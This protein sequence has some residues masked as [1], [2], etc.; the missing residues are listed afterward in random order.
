MFIVRHYDMGDGLAYNV[1]K[2]ILQDQKGF[3]W[4]ATWNGIDRFDG[5][6][7]RNFKSYPDDK[8][9]LNNNRIEGL[10][11]NSEGNL[12][13]RTYDRQLFLFNRETET[14]E[15]P[16]TEKHQPLIRDMKSLDN[17]I[18][19]IITES[20]DLYRIDD[21]QYRQPDGIRFFGRANNPNLGNTIYEIFLDGDGDEWILSDRG[22]I[23]E[24]RKKVNSNIPFRY[25]TEAGGIVYLASQNGYLATYNENG[26]LTPFNLPFKFDRI[27]RLKKLNEEQIAII[28]P[29]II[30]IYHT[31]DKTTQHFSPPEGQQF[32]SSESLFLDGKGVIW[33]FASGRNMICYNTAN[34]ER[35]VLDYP[36]LSDFQLTGGNTP[37]I[38]EDEHGEIWIFFRE[39]ILCTYNADRRQLEIARY[40][41]SEGNLR[42][43]TAQLR[44]FL[45]DTHHNLWICTRDGVDHLSFYKKTYDLIGNS[46]DEEVRGIFQ[47][48]YNRLW[49]GVKNG[50]I[51]LYDREYNHIGNL[52]G[53]GRIVQDN[54]AVFGATVYCF[55]RDDEGN[56]WI[57][58][59]DRGLF[60]LQPQN[61]REYRVTQYQPT[62]DP[63]SIS[64]LSVYSILQDSQKRMWIG[65]WGGGINLV[66]KDSVGNLQFIH[67]GNR[68]KNYPVEQ[69]G[70]V[71]YVYQSKNG[72]LMLGTTTGLITFSSRFDSPEEITFFYNFCTADRSDCLSNGNILYIF[73]DKNENIYV[74]TFSGGVN[75]T[76]DSP[77]LLSEEIHFQN[78]N[79][80]NG[81]ASDLSLSVIEDWEGFIWIVSVDAL[82]RFNP[83]T[84]HFDR[85]DREN[86]SI[87]PVISEA[88]P[89]INH[90]GNLIFGTAKGAIQMFTSQIQPGSFVPPIVFTDISVQGKNIPNGQKM[91]NR[92]ALT[93]SKNERNIAISFSSLDYSNPNSIH[94]AYRLQDS[95]SDWVYTG[96]NRTASFIDLPAGNHVFQVKSTNSDGI[97]VD[98]IVSLPIYVVPTFWETG[99]AWIIYAGG[100]LLFVLLVILIVTH[101]FKLRKQVDFEQELTRLKIK[102]FTDVS[103]EL[104]TPL[105]L[106]AN[107]IEEVLSNESLS[108]NGREYMNTAKQNTERMLRLI[109]QILDFRKIQNNKMKVK[110]EQTDIFALM[111]KV[112]HS[113]ST[114]A[115][116]K[117]IRY[118]FERTEKFREIYADTD[119]VEKILFNL[120]SNAFK[121]TPDGRS[122]TLISGI[123]K[124]GLF[125]R[126][127]DE[128][129]G[130]DMQKMERL[131]KR[132][133]TDSDTNPSISSGIGL[134]LVKELVNLLH[135]SIDVES[136]K[137]AGSTFS[138]RL[139]IGYEEFSGD[140]NVELILNDSGEA[141]AEEETVEH[142]SGETCILVIEDNEELRHFIK[143]ILSK[144]Y[145]VLEAANGKEG[146]DMTLKKFPDIVV[147]DIMMPEMDGVE[148]LN[149]VKKNHD[150]SHIPVI[151]LTA[152]SS[153]DDRIRGIE[154]GADD[155]ITKPFN[156]AY[157]K[158]KIAT[159]LKQRELLREYYLS[160]GGEG[161]NIRIHDNNWEPSMPKITNYDDEFITKVIQVIENNIDDSEFR[162]ETIAENLNMSRPVFYR[163]IKAIMGLSPI[164]FVKK[165]RI[166]RAVQL[167]ETKRFTVAEVAYQSGFNTPQYMSKIFRELTGYAPTKYLQ[168]RQENGEKTE[169]PYQNAN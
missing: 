128:G 64:S 102:F 104:R 130:F 141:E 143:N 125:I 60:V 6:T 166:K 42:N 118:T 55:Y 123:D 119:K 21:R 124:N 18:T 48:T 76:S 51:E 65:C 11:L 120:L 16:F 81:L 46:P 142:E 159:L 80:T 135:G 85:F 34:G 91:L 140:P 2:N 39:G 14:F 157:L 121:Y 101:I 57:G 62:D 83:A 117:Q 160:K 167:L 41:D 158:T 137:D 145:K 146:L 10:H 29:K 30:V 5:Y 136:V 17:G 43:Y 38:H 75:I 40:Y 79:K 68:L 25:I 98:N 97:W 87:S 106:I 162:I 19:Y 66:E 84:G 148:Y 168:N 113:F 126:V 151:L 131:F 15:N 103:H 161:F 116:R 67:A 122:I 105:T 164:D 49:L 115:N 134:S 132:F 110:L 59:R 63:Y 23:L 37:V 20:D 69:C 71:R 147:S 26:Q 155:Y 152:K 73:Q 13:V 35:T 33:T 74:S 89:I 129:S 165:I 1:N 36:D 86:L 92:E 95:E 138:V 100:F 45:I 93:L 28:T 88:A 56:I 90:S 114:L 50:K 149:A 108:E 144:E 61:E 112:F 47:D 139:P 94:Y 8:V 153:I 150:I 54:G 156:S 53:K 22:I 4:L 7:F 109:N 107:P 31:K 78:L 72:T 44:G 12:W 133:E 169:K 24:G 163:K 70:M 58:S 99:F 3:I 96:K 154:Y 27:N 111:E 52:N 82:N 9:K 127:K 32:L 77:E